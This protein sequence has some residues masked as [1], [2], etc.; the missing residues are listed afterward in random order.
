[1]YLLLFPNFS[2]PLSIALL[3][4]PFFLISI[5][6]Q[7]IT[8]LYIWCPVLSSHMYIHLNQFTLTFGVRTLV[9]MHENFD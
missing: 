9:G 8:Y 6:I 3:L 2:F 1:L 4:S 5:H 7:T